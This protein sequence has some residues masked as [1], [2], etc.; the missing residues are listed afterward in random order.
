MGVRLLLKKDES[1]GLFY[2][3]RGSVLLLARGEVSGNGFG[4]SC[5]NGRGGRSMCKQGVVALVL[6][7]RQREGAAAA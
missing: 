4:G 3:P 6:L 2:W 1:L 5:Q 7:L